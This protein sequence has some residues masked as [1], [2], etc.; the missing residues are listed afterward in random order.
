MAPLGR[1]CDSKMRDLVNNIIDSIPILKDQPDWLIYM[2]L[3]ITGFW[4]ILWAIRRYFTN[5]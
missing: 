3:N 4:L 2:L 5:S 1:T